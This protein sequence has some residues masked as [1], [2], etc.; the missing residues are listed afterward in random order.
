M[1]EFLRIQYQM[2]KLSKEQLQVFVG[3]YLSEEEYRQIV[4]E[5]HE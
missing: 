4:G 1:F 2:G 3:V 5:T